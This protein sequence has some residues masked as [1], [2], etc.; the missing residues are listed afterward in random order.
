MSAVMHE[1]AA[2]G[3][4]RKL[5]TATP[6][7]PR[8]A[9]VVIPELDT[10]TVDI[11]VRGTSE[12]IENKWASKAVQQMTDKQTGEASAG[13]ES[14]NPD[15]NFLDSLY[16]LKMGKIVGKFADGERT[17]DGHPDVRIEGGKFGFPS[18]GFK[19]SMVD[20]C[21]SLKKSITKIQARQSFHVLGELTEIFGA[22]RMRQDMVRLNGK[23]ADIRFRGA[24]PE[25]CAKLRINYNRRALSA[26]QLTNLLNVAGYAVG[27]GEFR[28]SKN[29]PY[30]RF[31]VCSEKDARE[32]L[33]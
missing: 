23:T 5:K 10:I 7:T 9:A 18:V 26:S 1:E 16:I 13:K 2:N 24:F 32:F 33:K 6:K 4:G 29:G 25:W 19:S 27:I 30:G 20:A 17:A 15:E 22:P 3:N 12:L 8:S 14:K 31:E 28:P 11:W 21:T